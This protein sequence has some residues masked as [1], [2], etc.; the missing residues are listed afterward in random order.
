VTG[1]K[2]LLEPGR[3]RGQLHHEV[4]L[5]NS[6]EAQS[7]YRSVLEQIEKLG[8]GRIRRVEERLEAT[9]RE[10]GVAFDMGAKSRWGAKPWQCDLLPHLVS[11]LEWEQL[12]E[13]LRQRL[14]VYEELLRDLYSERQILRSGS[15]PVQ[16]VLN[17]PYYQREAIRLP[18]PDASF[19]HL[20]GASI[21]RRPDGR[22]AF[23]HHYFSN[24]SGIAYMMQNRRA[25]ARVLP[26]LFSSF[27]VRPIIQTPTKILEVLRSFSS[28]TEPLVVL[29]SP[30]GSSAAFSEH[31]FLA[32][33]MGIP[34]VRGE[35]L[36]VMK[37]EV[38]LKTTGGLEK[39]HVIYSRLADPWL[40]PLV[41]RSDSKLGVPGLVNCIRQGSVVL[42]NTIG[43]QVADDRSLLAFD[44]VIF[45]FYR[46]AKPLIPCLPTYWLGDLD[47]REHVLERLEEFTIRPVYGE[48]VLTQP[49]GEETT[50]YRRRQILKEVIEKPGAYVAQPRQTGSLTLAFEAGRPT[51]RLQDQIL[52]AL[53][54]RSGSWEVF[55]GALTRVSSRNSA[56]VASELG[57]GSKDTWVMGDES[58]RVGPEAG[59]EKL[60]LEVPPPAHHVMSRTADHL[61][62]TGR[63]MERA[64]RL[65]GMV[66]TIEALELEELNPTERALYRP[67]WNR[68]LPPLENKE[69]GSRRNI[70]SPEGRFHLT[71]ATQEPGSVASSVVRAEENGKLEL[72][73]LGIEA[74]SALNQLSGK[75]SRSRLAL[76]SDSLQ[77]QLQTRRC[78]EATMALVPQ[79]FGT[80]EAT[81]LQDD[82]WGFCLVGQAL[83]RACITS[84]AI[85]SIVDSS[86]Q[87]CGALPDEIRLSAFLRMIGCRDLYRRVYQ[88]K[89][90]L[91]ELLHLLWANREVPLGVSGCLFR[92]ADFLGRK[93]S[94]EHA[95]LSVAAG[96]LSNLAERIEATDWLEMR[97]QPVHSLAEICRSFSAEVTTMH[98]V[99]SDSFFNHQI[100]MQRDRQPL[101]EFG[102]NSSKI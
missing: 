25:L 39:V 6:T 96:C 69:L 94:K 65:A 18:R 41:F 71:L 9:M 82:G 93:F 16:T 89:V 68:I 1:R 33:R 53:R 45:R 28:S 22:L 78:C 100:L 17:S 75:F 84:N 5:E 21:G 57:G 3:L 20:S 73:I 51:H 67:V 50:D 76:F 36:L 30:G 58:P 29:L 63:Y 60:H 13:A 38:F 15:L 56:H 92:C 77:N 90:D 4:L 26:E 70:S 74:M 80:A 62:W 43:S 11:S 44:D 8:A 40:D 35:D 37:D 32:R 42:I 31:A 2:R 66:S 47:Q 10:M 19:L 34:V 55:P 61:Y 48:R 102:S 59:E 14:D 98:D 97:R 52:F 99:L 86:I 83:E 95:L 81:I 27:S 88:M 101:L 49:F 7:A 87:Q 85:Y 12:D 46:N 54:H 91:P 72:D 79:F 64:Y 23:H 24:A